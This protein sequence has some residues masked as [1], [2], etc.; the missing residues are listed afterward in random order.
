M[1]LVSFSKDLLRA[2]RI[3]SSPARTAQGQRETCR[4]PGGGERAQSLP[5]TLRDNRRLA[6]RFYNAGPGG[7]RRA[8][9]AM[10]AA[11]AERGELTVDDP[12]CAAD[13]LVSLWEGSRPAMIAF[14]LAEPVAAA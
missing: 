8:L 10:I 9:A 4:Y 13:D 5:A 12:A 14:G 3:R 1:S 7:V 2:A 6:L 11:A